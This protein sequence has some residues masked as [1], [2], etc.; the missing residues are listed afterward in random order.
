MP[1][2]RQG[3]G[4]PQTAADIEAASDDE[5]EG[6]GDE[7]ADRAPP[8]RPDKPPAHLPP[9]FGYR[10]FTHQYDEEVAAEA[11]CDPEELTRLRGYL[12]TQLTS[13][14][15]AVTRLANR[16]QR[17]LLAQQRRAWD[18]DQEEGLLDPG[19]LARVIASPGQPLSYKIERDAEFSRY[20][21]HAAY[22]Q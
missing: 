17:R 20:R 9:D 3:R 15:G 7:S 10:A 22:R 6:T 1:K 12:D 21:R 13:L 19:R 8:T 4:D 14:Q 2:R 18:F 11:L 16:L 5:M